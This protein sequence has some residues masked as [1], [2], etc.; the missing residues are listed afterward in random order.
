[1]A[2]SSSFVDGTKG[3]LIYRG[4]DIRDLGANATFEEVIYLLWNGD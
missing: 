1:M 3:I 4:Y 2:T